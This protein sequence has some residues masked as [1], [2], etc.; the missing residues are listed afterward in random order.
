VPDSRVVFIAGIA[1]TLVV[2]R[3]Y[4]SINTEVSFAADWVTNI[5]RTVPAILPVFSLN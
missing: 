2:E 5:F 3:S 4:P 1:H